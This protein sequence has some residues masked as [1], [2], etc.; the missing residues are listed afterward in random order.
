[1][2]VSIAP[3]ISSAQVLEEDTESYIK[4]GFFFSLEYG[5]YMS[6]LK[7]PSLSSE[8]RGQSD[9]LGT[10]GG[11]QAGYDINKNFSLQ[12]LFLTTQVKGHSQRGGGS[13]SYIFNLSATYLFSNEAVFFFMQSLVVGLC[14]LHLQQSIKD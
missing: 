1:L 8:T 7:P 10:L 2:L 3:S 6:I 12:F 13:G 14:S 9:F 11:I 4:H 5:P